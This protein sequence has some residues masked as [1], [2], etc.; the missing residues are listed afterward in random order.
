MPPAS[1]AAR[2]PT[3][4]FIRHAWRSMTTPGSRSCAR[5]TRCA[6]AKRRRSDGR[7]TSCAVS[8]VRA[9]ARLYKLLAAR[10][11]VTWDGRD[12]D[13]ADWAGADTVNRC[14]SAATA[15]SMVSPRPRCWRLVRSGDWLPAY[16]QAAELCLRHR[17][18]LQIRD[19][20]AGRLSCRR[21]GTDRSPARRRPVTDPVAR[22]APPLPRCF[23]PHADLDAADPA[24]SR[25][26]WRPAGWQCLRAPPEAMPVAFEEAE[27]LGDAGH[28]G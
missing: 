2:A 13:P 18:S 10:H 20:R 12:Y 14:L 1:R 28:R 7:S 8:R 11:G 25:R 4:C 26:C 22:G 6:L 23:P 3:G 19:S 5:C 15:A 21:R 9:C 24:R 27:K 17:R 16:W